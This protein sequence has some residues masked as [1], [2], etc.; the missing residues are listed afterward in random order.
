MPSEDMFEV[1]GDRLRE[2]SDEAAKVRV[3]TL[4][5]A[6]TLGGLISA[7]ERGYLLK[8]YPSGANTDRPMECVLR[9]FTLH[10]GGFCPNDQDIRDA[11][12]WTSGIMEHWYKVS[13]LIRALDN[14]DGKYGID[15][16]I[17]II[18]IR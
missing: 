17:A 18:E 2:L 15:K 7:V 12:V 9:A 11:Y 8:Y 4:R 16:P 13:D 3:L 10:G 1:P 6:G 14:L 5:E